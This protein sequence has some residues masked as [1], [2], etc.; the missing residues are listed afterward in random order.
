MK[1]APLPT[2]DGI[3]P[4]YIWLP[5]GQWQHALHF[6][7]SHFPEVSEQ[8]WLTRFA[9][10]EVCTAEGIA[11]TPNSPVKRGM[12][13]YYYR[14]VENE[15]AIPFQET[16]LFQNEDLLVVDK[17]HFLPVTPGG[18]YLKETLLVRLKNSTGIDFLTPL[19]R[20]D[21]E[22]AGVI[23]LSCNPKTRGRYQALFQQ[24]QIIKTYHAIAA[25]LPDLPTPY[26]K[27]SRL[28]ESAQFFVMHEVEG[29][30]NTE[31]LISIIERRGENALYQL[32]PKTGKKHQLRVHLA[33]LGAP[34]LN[35]RFYP[36]ALP[37]GHDDFEKPLKLLAKR[38]SFIDPHS[39]EH[40]HFESQLSL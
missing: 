25:F 35:D 27:Q 39:Q 8:I 10:H 6:L 33:S 18:N 28:E 26:L 31:T 30:A 21:R 24:N 3:S 19:H 13:I 17:P 7:C 22:T 1:S 14:E 11:L 2:R 12:C 23:L 38:I 32:Q 36:Q 16:I 9:K 40:Y 37:V 20:L 5:E 15:I 4:S 34:I 29:E